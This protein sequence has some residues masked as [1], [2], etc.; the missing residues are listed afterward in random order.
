MYQ[1]LFSPLFELVKN[2]ETRVDFLGLVNKKDKEEFLS[3]G[4]KQWY[5]VILEQ[6][7]LNFMIL[8]S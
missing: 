4:Y 2:E 6:I 8:M 5:H 3:L 7:T 1:A